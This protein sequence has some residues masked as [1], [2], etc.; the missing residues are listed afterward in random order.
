MPEFINHPACFVFHI[1]DN[2]GFCQRFRISSMV[3]SKGIVVFSILSLLS[4][5]NGNVNLL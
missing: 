5:V 3:L 2:F 1:G 4:K